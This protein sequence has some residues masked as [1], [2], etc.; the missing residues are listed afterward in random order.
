MALRRP[1]TPSRASSASMPGAVA[2]EQDR[3]AVLGGRAHRALDRA[4][5]REVPPHGVDRDLHA[6]IRSSGPS[7]GLFDGARTGSLAEPEDGRSAPE[8]DAYRFSLT[9]IT[10]RPR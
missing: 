9:S 10:C 2:D 3:G 5:R 4:L 6:R 8:A 7:A 1:E